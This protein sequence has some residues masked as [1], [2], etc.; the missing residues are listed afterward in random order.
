[1]PNLLCTQ[2]S[3]TVAGSGANSTQQPGLVTGQPVGSSLSGATVGSYAWSLGAPAGS[4]A[5]LSSATTATPTWIPDLPG[6]YLLTLNGT[7]TLPLLVAQVAATTYTGPIAPALITSSQAS[8]PTS[9]FAAFADA[10]N[11]GAPMAKFAD[12]NTAPF[13]MARSGATGARPI[14]GLFVGYS[15]FDTTLGLPIFWTGSAWVKAD[16]SAA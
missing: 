15:Y 16:G 9:G 8:T 11:S 13:Q 4:D 2:G 6:V 7:Y 5:V 12:G 10:Q 14:A 1:M 3:T